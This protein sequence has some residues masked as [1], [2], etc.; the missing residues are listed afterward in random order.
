[1]CKY[2]DGWEDRL[3]YGVQSVFPLVCSRSDFSDQLEVDSVQDI[4]EGYL[5]LGLTYHE[6]GSKFVAVK[7][8]HEPVL[9]NVYMSIAPIKYCPFCGK[10]LI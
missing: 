6:N 2:C 10:K 7:R 5:Y 9:V 3:S 1:M 4:P 8:I